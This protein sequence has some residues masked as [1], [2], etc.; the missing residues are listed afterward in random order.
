MKRFTILFLLLI[1]VIHSF[2]THLIG[3][4][5]TYK[6]LE[7]YKDSS[8][9]FE[10]TV[11]V[12]R[13]QENSTVAF[14]DTAYV[15]IYTQDNRDLIKTLFLL[16]SPEK[17]LSTYLCENSGFR[18]RYAT[19]YKGEVILPKDTSGYRITWERCCRNNSVNISNGS[20]GEPDKPFYF[21]TE[22]PNTEV[23]NSSA[24]VQQYVK[25]YC[26]IGSDRWSLSYYDIDGDSVVV[27]LQEFQKGEAS[28]GQFSSRPAPSPTFIEPK[29]TEL[30]AGYNYLR[31]FGIEFKT[32]MTENRLVVVE[33][34]SS[35]KTGLYYV[36]F[37]I[38]EFRK[39]ALISKRNVDGLAY[40]IDCQKSKANN[41]PV[42]L[43][44]DKM[45]YL[46]PRLTWQGCAQKVKHYQVLSSDFST[47]NF[48]EIAKVPANT[49]THV[50]TT[51][52][53]KGQYFYQIK[54]IPLDS[55]VS[56]I[57]NI[58][59]VN[60]FGLNAQNYSRS[61]PVLIYPNPT[62][63]TLNLKSSSP[64]LSIAVLDLVGHKMAEYSYSNE[65]TTASLSLNLKAGMYT[66]TVETTDGLAVQKIWVE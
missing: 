62:N 21:T 24:I 46:K 44:A 47:A 4:D 51:L 34:G 59:A 13:D 9:R 17:D 36:S 23:L 19:Y 22:I 29:P 50:D 41:T 11:T 45:E 66:C 54:G 61:S 31:P 12:L 1:C 58:A 20:D 43:Q 65:K 37:L 49:S 10:I 27:T 7:T 60:Y 42:N 15:G 35:V 8:V 28:L 53:T 55:Q 14:D 5:I 52:K 30:N 64:I 48:Q 2:A 56:G 39:S 6:R 63:G 26:S 16:K 18:G 57:S 33:S 40:V 3:G 32:E 38:K 25:V